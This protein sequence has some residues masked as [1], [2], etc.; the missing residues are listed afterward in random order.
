[1]PDDGMVFMAFQNDLATGFVRA[2]QRLHGEAL[3]PYLLT[4]GGGYFVVPTLDGLAA[5]LSVA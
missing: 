2:Q 4:V 3:S 1:V 5:V